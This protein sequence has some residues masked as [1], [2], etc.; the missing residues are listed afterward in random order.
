MSL[1]DFKGKLFYI[2]VTSG[3]IAGETH[4]CGLSQSPTIL[5]SSKDS[6]SNIQPY[7]FYPLKFYF[8]KE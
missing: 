5:L 7:F 2:S 8:I 4:R 3:R 6:D 1:E